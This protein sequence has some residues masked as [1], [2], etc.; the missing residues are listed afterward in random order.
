MR[1]PKNQVVARGSVIYDQA[2]SQS[3]DR[4]VS[5]QT[6]SQSY[7][8]PFKKKTTAYGWPAAG[9]SHMASQPASHMASQPAIWPFFFG[10][11]TGAKSKFKSKF[12]F[13]L[14]TCP[15]RHKTR[16]GLKTKNLVLS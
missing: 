2:G 4:S 10:A 6:A 14:A 15:A 11:K 16:A 7:G 3:Y 5:D 13:K 12:K 1:P 9:A 8:Q